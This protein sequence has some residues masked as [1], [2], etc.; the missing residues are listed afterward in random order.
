MRDPNKI[1]LKIIHNSFFG[2]SI[3][4]AILSTILAAFP[5][6]QGGICWGGHCYTYVIDTLETYIFM[7]IISA[8]F[9]TIGM[10][11]YLIRRVIITR[12]S[13]RISQEIESR[14]Y[15]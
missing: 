11:I 6:Y 14:K 2:L 12:P 4:I 15:K 9:L 13:T 10:G 5:R 3:A 7:L 8:G 1:F